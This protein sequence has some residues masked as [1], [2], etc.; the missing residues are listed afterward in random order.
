M[1]I[2]PPP[3]SAMAGASARMRRIGAITCSSTAHANPSS[4][5]L[6]RPGAAD[7]GVVDQGQGASWHASETRARRRPVRSRPGADRPVTEY[8]KHPGP[9]VPRAW[10]P[11]RHRCRGWRGDHAGLTSQAR[12]IGGHDRPNEVAPG[13]GAQGSAPGSEFRAGRRSAPAPAARP[14]CGARCAILQRMAEDDVAIIRRMYEARMASDDETVFATFART[15]DNPDPGVLGGDRRDLCRARGREALPARRLRG[16]LGLPL[17][18][19][20]SSKRV[21]AGCSRLPSST[22]GA[23]QRRGGGIREDGPPVDAA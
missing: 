22:A 7:A 9:L 12:S 11:S 5:L 4:Q 1:T 21:K 2:R 16:V 19:S 10:R 23:R 15:S 3:A 6:E 17:R 18:S 13:P 14:C 20:R 8:A